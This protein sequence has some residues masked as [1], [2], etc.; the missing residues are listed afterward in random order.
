VHQHGGR[1][2]PLSRWSSIAHWLGC[3]HSGQQSGA[4][5]TSALTQAV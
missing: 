5:E 2:W 4:E 1:D 3:P